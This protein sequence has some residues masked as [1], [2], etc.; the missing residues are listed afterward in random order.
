M[1]GFKKAEAD[2][3]LDLLANAAVV[4]RSAIRQERPIVDRISAGR[5]RMA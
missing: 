3:R 2:L 4:L 5:S 1:L